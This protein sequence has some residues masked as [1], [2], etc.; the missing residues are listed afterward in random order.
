MPAGSAGSGRGGACTHRPVTIR[1]AG[2]LSGMDPSDALDPTLLTLL[3]IAYVV[4]AFLLLTLALR[5]NRTD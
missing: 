1:P 2:R 5:T 3:V 4:V